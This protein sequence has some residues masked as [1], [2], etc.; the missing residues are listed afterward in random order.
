[1]H[2]Q[3]EERVKTSHKLASFDLYFAKKTIQTFAFQHR[4]TTARN[5]FLLLCL[6]SF[7]SAKVY[8]EE[9]LGLLVSFLI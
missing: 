9:E 8:R 4:N 3:H 7:T 6:G 2:V 1:M 5:F